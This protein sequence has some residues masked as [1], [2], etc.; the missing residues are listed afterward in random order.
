MKYAK[1]IKMLQIEHLKLTK[2]NSITNE[3]KWHKFFHK[4]S[5]IIDRCI[6]SKRINYYQFDEISTLRYQL[7]D[8]FEE[9]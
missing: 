2:N 6:E 7:L 5:K 9:D 8:T 4:S 1:A 3:E